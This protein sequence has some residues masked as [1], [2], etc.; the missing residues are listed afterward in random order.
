MNN[1]YYAKGRYM[2]NSFRKLRCI[3]VLASLTFVMLL[4]PVG[5]SCGADTGGKLSKFDV[6]GATLEGKYLLGIAPGPTWKVTAYRMAVYRAD[7]E[8]GDITVSAKLLK[9]SKAAIDQPDR[10]MSVDITGPFPSPGEF[11]DN[12]PWSQEPQ[13]SATFKWDHG[14]SDPKMRYAWIVYTIGNLKPSLGTLPID[15]KTDI[16]ILPKDVSMYITNGLFGYGKADPPL[17]YPDNYPDNPAGGT[18]GIDVDGL[19]P[20][21]TWKTIELDGRPLTKVPCE[22]AGNPGTGGIKMPPLGTWTKS[23]STSWAGRCAP[24]ECDCYYLSP[25]DLKFDIETRTG[26]LEN[27]QINSFIKSY[28]RTQK[29]WI[30]LPSDIK[31]GLHELT[32]T[33]E[34]YFGKTESNATFYG[35]TGTEG[36]RLTAKFLLF[37]PRFTL[38]KSQASP[39]DTLTITGSG[40]AP[41]ARVKI[42]AQ[43][44]AFSREVEIGSAITN[45][46]GGFTQQVNIP[47]TD[48]DFFKDIWN[49]YETG[50]EQGAIR[51]KIDD[52]NFQARYSSSYVSEIVNGVITP[53]TY[54]KPVTT[55]A[56]PSTQGVPTSPTVSG[57]S[58]PTSTS[59]TGKAATPAGNVMPGTAGENKITGFE[60]FGKDADR[61]GQGDNGGPDGKAD[62]HFRLALSLPSAAEIKSIAIYSAGPDGKPS[63]GQ[64]W[65]SADASY[66]ILG[67][68]NQGQQLNQHHVP[69]LGRLSGDVQLDLYASDSGEFLP[70]NQFLAEATLGDGTKLQSLVSVFGIL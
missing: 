45:S 40:F 24:Y 51:V 33:T 9:D 1:T 61:V 38:D 26:F 42:Y 57:T 10:K 39:G 41:V 56:M 34:P 47:S 68:F 69:T 59:P 16:L 31:A 46:T 65:H 50:P 20:F 63:G 52:P 22:S 13:V 4:A 62:G 30:S 21:A 64:V 36:R 25:T 29:A 37:G 55:S 28:T 67:V 35:I 3:A 6:N 66:W 5:I 11:S 8:T 32:L 2:M 53:L 12:R 48:S 54:I 19:S 49:E 7:A 23:D 44:V 15:I 17:V 27:S 18:V 14:L 43:T 60:W 70:G 58:V